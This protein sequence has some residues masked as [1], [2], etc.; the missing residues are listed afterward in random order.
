VRRGPHI[1]PEQRSVPAHQEGG[2]PGRDH[3]SNAYVIGKANTKHHYPMARSRFDSRAPSAHEVVLLHILYS[4]VGSD[5]RRSPL[6]D[7][8][9]YNPARQE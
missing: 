5:A 9:L 1:E 8:A 7:L 3:G 6:E 2:L 4:V